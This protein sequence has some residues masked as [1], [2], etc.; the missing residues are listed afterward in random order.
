MR[1]QGPV[2]ENKALKDIQ[3]FLQ[4]LVTADSGLKLH[5]NAQDKIIARF[6]DGREINLSLALRCANLEYLR[7]SA[8]QR[9]M[10]TELVRRF[11]L[12]AGDS[13]V[14]HSDLEGEVVY[15][16]EQQAITDY[17]KDDYKWMN[18]LLRGV[19][20][21]KEPEALKVDA[22]LAKFVVRALLV[23]SG[24]NKLISMDADF[25]LD[26]DSEDDSDDDE[27]KRADAQ[28]RF[29][30]RC[31][32]A[33][34]ESMVRRL[35][36]TPKAHSVVTV[37]SRIRL[38]G[39]ISTTQEEEGKNI[40]DG[41]WYRFKF[42][43][44]HQRC[45]EDIS[46]NASE[47]EHLF[48]PHSVHVT[49]R[50]A[51][52]HN[53][54]VQYFYDLEWLGGLAADQPYRY[55]VELAYQRIAKRLAEPYVD[56]P[57]PLFGVVRHNHALAHHIRK[58]HY[59]QPVL[60]YFAKHAKDRA[61]KE[62]CKHVD[63]RT[64]ALLK[65]V[66]LFSRTG[67]ESENGFGD[68]PQRYREY[69][70]AS[71]EYLVAY[72]E[73]SG[74]F[75]VAE[76]AMASNCLKSMFIPQESSGVLSGWRMVVEM[77]HDLDLPRCYTERSYLQAMS[78]Y[79]QYQPGKIN[80]ALVLQSPKQQRDL[81][82]LQQLAMTALVQTGDA[83][84][85]SAHGVAKVDY[86]SERFFEANTNVDYCVDCCQAALIEV[87]SEQ[88]N[89][90]A[91]T[92][93]I[94][95][96]NTAQ[97]Q[98]MISKMSLEGLNALQ[99]VPVLQLVVNSGSAELFKQLIDK[100]LECNAAVIK[101][102]QLLKLALK[103]K[104]KPLLDLVLQQISRT[105]LLALLPSA[106]RLLKR[107]ISFGGLVGLMAVVDK[108]GGAVLDVDGNMHVCIY[109]ALASRDEAVLRF[110]A[111]RPS[112][113][114]DFKNEKGLTPAAVALKKGLPAVATELLAR[115]DN[116]TLNEV[117]GPNNDSYLHLAVRMND[118]DNVNALL[119]RGADLLQLDNAGRSP[120][121]IVLNG[122]NCE[123]IR[124]CLDFAVAHNMIDAIN[125]ALRGNANPYFT[126]VAYRSMEVMQLLMDYGIDYDVRDSDNNSVIDCARDF[127]LKA[128][129]R[130]LLNSL[131]TRQLKRQEKADHEADLPTPVSHISGT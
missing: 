130:L 103:A 50:Q 6:A 63:L 15:A 11:D 80:E 36:I 12:K 33:L 20:V 90:Q 125:V 105:E 79:G 111:V 131:L 35:N 19:A 41:D 119:Q 72:L 46:D 66:L 3:L 74:E 67:R 29:V 117:L 45:I 21:P 115:L 118:V 54:G 87:A 4:Q 106:K 17:T 31:T 93:A 102:L 34:P 128:P 16:A 104:S 91:L 25:V 71:S 49:K 73:G 70:Q 9:A 99:P 122:N 65:L 101:R 39:M 32:G 60:N 108:V 23:I 64:I 96:K 109:Q 56:S 2:Q 44:G 40:G 7:I 83:V 121:S 127:H 55:A 27:V 120:I 113:R 58:A 53:S 26:D 42:A 86:D 78:R 82:D 68:N 8:E 38:N 95:R 62:F 84:M 97:A 18:A 10:M 22:N 107:A 100:G 129:E 1:L 48:A 52:K 37:D 5:R 24:T 81:D 59:L 61:V 114:S 28:Q 14:L 13:S 47:R 98:A 88:T 116:A 110:L 94:H 69:V 75:S 51:S 76:I 92:A 112:F 89:E 126:H 77:A 124:T 30:Y 123:L 43:A 57:D 85:F